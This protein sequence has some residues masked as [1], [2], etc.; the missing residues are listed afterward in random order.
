MNS[1]VGHPLLWAL[2]Q[3]PIDCGAEH[4]QPPLWRPVV[5]QPDAP[6]GTHDAE[7]GGGACRP[8]VA[9]F[10]LHSVTVTSVAGTVCADCG[11]IIVAA[12]RPPDIRHSGVGRA[13]MLR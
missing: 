6:G 10:C 11:S 8:A 12:R 3:A 2:R 9:F 5:A 7:G 4:R 13:R 1:D